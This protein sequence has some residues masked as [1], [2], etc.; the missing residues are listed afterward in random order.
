MQNFP[1]QPQDEHGPVFNEPWEA[2]AFALVIALHEQGLF[3]WAEWAA[4][5]SEKIAAAQAAG[6]PD[7]GDSYYQ[8]W[9]AALESISRQKNLSTIDELEERKSQWHA[10]YMNTPHGKPIELAAGEQAPPELLIE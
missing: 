6:D 9:L 5:L 7:L 8:H 4:V 10:A 3:S 1:H 2:Q